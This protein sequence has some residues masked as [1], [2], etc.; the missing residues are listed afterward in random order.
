MIFRCCY[1]FIEFL[2]GEGGAD[3]NVADHTKNTALHVACSQVRDLSL[4]VI[5]IQRSTLNFTL[6]CQ[7]FHKLISDDNI[8]K[9]Q[10]GTNVYH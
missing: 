7:R 9:H 2:V 3:I 10:L 5:S 8:E 1:S 4:L 6:Q